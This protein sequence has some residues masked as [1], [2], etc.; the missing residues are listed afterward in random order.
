[1]VLDTGFMLI[2]ILFFV[3]ALGSLIQVIRCVMKKDYKAKFWIFLILFLV[4][5][6]M[7]ISFIA[8]FM[9]PFY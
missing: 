6:L 5:L 1:M 3:I 7:G 2:V 9:K 4:F 8:T